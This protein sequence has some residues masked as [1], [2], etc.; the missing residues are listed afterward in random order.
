[1][2]EKVHMKKYRMAIVGL[3][4]TG[5][6][7]A[8]ALL[9]KDP[10]TILVGRSD[11]MRK[12]LSEDGIR[13]SGELSFSAP[14]QSYCGS[15]QDLGKYGPNLIFIS[16]KTCDLARVLD[17]LA[18]VF[19]PGTKIVSTHNGLGTEDL[20]SERF[21]ADSAFR[22]SLNLGVARIGPGQVKAAFFNPPNHL[23]ALIPENHK[24]GEDI[25][26]LFTDA[27]LDTAYVDDIK[28]HVW[29]KMVM[30]C[31][32]ASI[33]T[34]TDKTIKEALHFPPTREIADEC[35]KEIVTVA[36]A[37]GY[38]LGENDINQAVA[39]LEKAGVHKDSMCADIENRKATEIDFLGG[40]VV[41]YARE[42]GIPVPYFTTMTN[43]VKSLESGYLGDSAK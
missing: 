15:I 18:T 6:V 13:V 34:V 39:Y 11:G 8:A 30:K 42:V 12:T 16:T 37:K 38:H 41:A 4:A 5:T 27:G 29:K 2:S 21:G 1:M 24:V 3:G 43:L 23:G 32:M 31:T 28:L 35:F 36:A 22:M 26:G 9:R 33:C 7:L 40:K 19:K 10:G 25:A 20:I 17:E 14:A